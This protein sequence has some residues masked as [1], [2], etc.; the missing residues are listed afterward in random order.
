LIG[1]EELAGI[2]RRLLSHVGG[3]ANPKDGTIGVLYTGLGVWVRLY[4]GP[5]LGGQ[6]EAWQQLFLDE[7]DAR[8][9]VQE[10]LDNLKMRVSGCYGEILKRPK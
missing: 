3:S 6:Q 7:Y 9:G 4:L 5:K 1:W 8:L 2:L 10:F